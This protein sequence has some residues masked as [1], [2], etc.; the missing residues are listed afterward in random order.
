MSRPVDDEQQGTHS[1][2]LPQRAAGI[3]TNLTWGPFD[4][5]LTL[6][7][8][9]SAIGFGAAA[10]DGSYTQTSVVIMAAGV[11]LV[12]VTLVAGRSLRREDSALTGVTLAVATVAAAAAILPAGIYG[13]DTAALY[14]SRAL[15]GVAALTVV[16]WALFGRGRGR[17][18]AYAVVAT[19]T[20]AGVAMVLASPRPS[21]DTWYMLQAATHGLSHGH[22]IYTL[23]WTSGIPGEVT[24]EFAYLPGSA[25]L[26]WP[27][28]VLFGDVRYGLLTAMVVTAL[29]LIRISRRPDDALVACLFLL[30]PRLLFGLEQSWLDPLTLLALC[31]CGYAVIRGRRGWAVVAF[32]VAL[33]CKPYTWMLVPFAAIWKDFGW[34]RTALSAAAAAVFI[35]PWAAANL[36]AFVSG[37]INLNLDLGFRRDSLSLYTTSVLH[38][39]TPGLWFPAT[40]IVVAF[41]LAL[42]RL[43]RDTYGFFLGTATVVALFDLFDRL[44]FFNEWE[45]AAGLTF[46]AV[47]F[48]R[49]ASVGPAD[50]GP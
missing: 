49:S 10:T 42:W 46:F 25:V 38:G 18:T 50:V 30:Y 17:L 32:A 37:A 43:P 39:L 20:A 35:L 45:F 41:G 8:A 16:A 31:L 47:V 13:T 29:T 3:R 11:A 4:A 19:M 33:T 34:R 7:A 9:W 40:A 28:H 6:L 24:N 15:T 44:S 12:V 21:I 48:G 26:L 2:R 1:R 23:R 27:F 5:N 36:H 22:D 14:L